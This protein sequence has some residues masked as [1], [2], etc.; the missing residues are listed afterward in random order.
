M[1]N[2]VAQPAGYQTVCPY[3]L[4]RDA[5]AE[6]RFLAEV[7]GAVEIERHERPDGTVGHAEVRIGDSVVMMGCSS[8]PGPAQLYVYVADAD[9]AYRRALERGATTVREPADQFYG[10]RVAGF[11]DPQSITWW[12]STH[13]E[14]VSPEEMTRRAKAAQPQ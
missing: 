6:M 8:S 4:V 2:V 13:V 5:A 9:G 1:R 12:V 3:L 14:D 10:D 11:T 7:F